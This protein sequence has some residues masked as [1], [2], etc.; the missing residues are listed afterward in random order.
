MNKGVSISA[1]SSASVFFKLS[2]PG[3]FL[4]FTDLMAW[5]ISLLDGTSECSHQGL[6]KLP[7]CLLS[8]LEVVC[9]ELLL[10][11]PN[12]VPFL[13]FT[14]HIGCVAFSCD[15]LGDLIHSSLFIAFCRFLCR[16]VRSSMYFHLSTLADF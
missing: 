3:A 1:T 8:P 15:E 12:T 4:F 7:G 6:L 11:A 14:K 10:S 5:M 13:A 9:L 2:L 16:D